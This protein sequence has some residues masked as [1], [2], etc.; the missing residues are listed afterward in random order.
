MSE[1]SERKIKVGDEPQEWFLMKRGL[2]WCPNAQGYTSSK[3]KAGRYSDERS[4]AW[5]G[6]GEG[7]VT[8][9]L[10]TSTLTSH[11]IIEKLV[12]ALGNECIPIRGRVGAETKRNEALTAAQQ[13]LKDT[14]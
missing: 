9:V 7:E 8:R 13:W 5:V 4:K 2:Y 11:E 3:A 6:H 10:A 14:E 1:P 12:A